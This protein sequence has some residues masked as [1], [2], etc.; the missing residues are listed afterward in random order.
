MLRDPNATVSQAN[1]LAATLREDL[2]G[3]DGIDQANI[4]LDLNVDTAAENILE[5]MLSP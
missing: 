1:A 5:K 4:F 3:S 2:E